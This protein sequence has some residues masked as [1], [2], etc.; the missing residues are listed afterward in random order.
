[1]TVNANPTVTVASQTV[2]ASALPVNI[3]ATPVGTGPFNYAWTGPSGPIAGNTASVSASVAGAYTVVVTDANGCTGSNSGTLTIIPQPDIVS[4]TQSGTDVVL[5][6]TSLE[7]VSYQV[8]Y[9]TDLVPN[10]PSSTWTDLGSPVTASG[11]TATFTDTS[12]AA[13]QRF[14]QISVV[15]SQ[16]PE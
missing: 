14:Y 8:Q 6:W 5:V 11:P 4:I 1:L 12:P 7:G 15:C 9:T 3:T 10:P 2:C 13:P 16:P